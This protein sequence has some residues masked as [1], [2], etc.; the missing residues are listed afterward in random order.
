[1]LGVNCSASSHKN[2]NLCKSDL[3]NATVLRKSS[4]AS[5]QALAAI[6]TF[7][8]L[9]SSACDYS[10]TKGLVQASLWSLTSPLAQALFLLIHVATL[11]TTKI[12]GE[13]EGQ[14]TVAIP[15]VPYIIMIRFRPLQ[16]R[17]PLEQ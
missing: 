11:L 17:Q 4:K 9:E 15:L 12:F 10:L 3:L 1:M 5:I 7:T 14:I 13:F 2:H 16:K 6:F 8:F